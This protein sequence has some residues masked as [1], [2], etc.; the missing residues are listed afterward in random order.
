MKDWLQQRVE[1]H[2]SGQAIGVYSVCSAHPMVLEAVANLAKNTSTHLM[3]ESTC[4][5]V[6][7]DG[8]YT[9]LRPADFV[10]FVAR[11]AGKVGLPRQRVLFGGDHLGPYPW[12]QLP[13]QHAMDKAAELVAQ[14]VSAG[15]TKI[16]IDTSMKCSDDP[17]GPL[18]KL[19]IARRTAALCR[20]AEEAG[21]RAQNENL[22]YVIGTE[23]PL[24]GGVAG[25]EI[26][27][28]ITTPSDVSETLSCMHQAF[29]QA[30]LDPAW[31]RVIAIVVQP[32]VEYG[33]DGIQE[34]KPELS[35]RLS[36]FIEGYENLV[37][38]AHSTDYQTRQSLRSLVQ[39]H[40]MI[41]KV[42]PALTFKFREAAFALAHIEEVLFPQGSSN[43]SRLIDTIDQ[44]MQDYPVYWKDYYQGS[45]QEMRLERYYSF[46]DRIRYYWSDQNVIRA[47][48]RLLKNLGGREIPLSLVSQY[49]PMQ[50][51][52]IR[53]GIL[54]NHPLSLIADQIQT[55]L[56][57]YHQACEGYA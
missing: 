28:N 6:N 9:G 41:L 36:R 42:G 37:Y 56:W 50:Y 15:Y 51:P 49:F 17:V 11:I 7:Q 20:A 54:A 23:V 1:D 48:T 43:L 24:P 13:A 33:N 14:Y 31:D 2:R 29:S 3:V 22:S 52:K 35:Y 30:N 53:S 32:G 19:T 55:V 10:E 21:K 39:D 40:F 8:G 16:H 34:Y 38:E 12:S 47:L 18:S 57:D 44:V 27:M 26:G 25:P 46:S 45:S 5:Q 4:N